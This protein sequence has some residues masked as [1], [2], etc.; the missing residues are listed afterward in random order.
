MRVAYLYN[1]PVSEGDAMDCEKTFADWNGTDRAELMDMLNRHGVREGDTLCLRAVSDLGQ[2]QES[3]RLQRK[4]ADMG[5][6]IE[7]IPTNEKKRQRGRPTKVE[8][9][10]M[11]EWDACCALWYSPAPVRHAVQRISERVGGEVNRNWINY[12]CGVR[13][14]SERT[15]KR[16]EMKKRL[17]E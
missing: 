10:D 17:E 9:S 2:G 5:V 1:R 7:I 11:D 14:G 12:R 16:A 8:I 6:H 13:D 15:E 4:I 3:A